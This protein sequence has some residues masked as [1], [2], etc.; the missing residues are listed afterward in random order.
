[1]L[2]VWHVRGGA[3]KPMLVKAVCDVYIQLN[4]CS[5]NNRP[6]CDPL[7]YTT[8]SQTNKNNINNTSKS[9]FIGGENETV[10]FI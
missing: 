3:I 7:V 6:L 9:S 1:M 10:I 5:Y 2:L 4:K 8:Y